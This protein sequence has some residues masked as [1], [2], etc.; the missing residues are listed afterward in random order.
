MQIYVPN[1]GHL[2]NIEG[3]LGRLQVN[4]DLAHHLSVSFHNRWVSVH[5]LVLSMVAWRLVR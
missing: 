4:S 2:G 1:S 5:P 3:F